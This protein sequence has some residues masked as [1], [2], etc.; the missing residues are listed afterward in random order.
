M[1]F[2]CHSKKKL[3]NLVMGKQKVHQIH[4]RN[5]KSWQEKTQ[6]HPTCKLGSFYY[7]SHSSSIDIEIKL[8]VK[9]LN[10]SLIA[11]SF[12]MSQHIGLFQALHLHSLRIVGKHMQYH[13]H[14]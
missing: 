11:I 10:H 5:A 1:V 8:W 4:V 12:L 9:I 6:H 7:H 2:W 13:N 14:M 3:D